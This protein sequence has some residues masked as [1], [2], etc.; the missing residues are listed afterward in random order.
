MAL[1][2]CLS[3]IEWSEFPQSLKNNCVWFYSL[4]Q[5]EQIIKA[6]GLYPE[7][8]ESLFFFH[9][10]ALLSGDKP[11][12]I[13]SPSTLFILKQVKAQVDQ[14]YQLTPEEMKK[15][16]YELI[17]K[18]KK[19]MLFDAILPEIEKPHSREINFSRGNETKEAVSNKQRVAF[20]PSE[21]FEQV[22]MPTF[23]ESYQILKEDGR[24]DESNIVFNKCIRIP[25][26]QSV[27]NESA[28]KTFFEKNLIEQE[29]SYVKN[30]MDFPYFF[31][32]CVKTPQK[33]EFI[34]VFSLSFGFKCLWPIDLRQPKN[35]FGIGRHDG[36]LFR[37]EQIRLRGSGEERQS[38][39]L[40]ELRNGQN[41]TG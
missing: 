33:E 9:E 1:I 2:H 24:L 17:K 7:F 36:P 20:S 12:V 32:F 11:P 18:E 23:A 13:L 35:G 14:F 31:D 27:I 3:A 22:D 28:L 19:W 39:D 21:S 41:E 37:E 10:R 40:Q 26:F 5:H 25:P 34:L 30:V 8:I 29:Y 16:L 38:R 15:V 4:P 6:I